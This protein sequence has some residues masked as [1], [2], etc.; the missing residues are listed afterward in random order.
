MTG[1]GFRIAMTILSIIITGLAVASAVF[2]TG[3]RHDAPLQRAYACAFLAA[4]QREWHLA[5]TPCTAR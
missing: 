2:L 4:G 3:I 5:A 1:H